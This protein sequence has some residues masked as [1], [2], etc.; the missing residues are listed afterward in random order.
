VSGVIQ[1]ET[2]IWLGLTIGLVFIIIIVAIAL[3]NSDFKPK[4]SLIIVSIL[5][6][7]IV[8]GVL[9]WMSTLEK[10]RSGVS[11]MKEALE[12]AKSWW[13]NESG[14][15]LEIAQGRGRSI[16]DPE[17]GE[18][19]FGFLLA[20]MTS[21]NPGAYIVILVGGKPRD[22]VDWFDDPPPILIKNPLAYKEKEMKY[23]RWM[24]QDM[25]MR[26]RQP[27]GSIPIHFE[28]TTPRRQEPQDFE[29]GG[30]EKK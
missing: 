7:I 5:A 21:T 10:K 30:E 13:Y 14:E 12:Y 1:R 19:T 29:K 16:A 23:K 27:S 25:E 6:V 8:G 22:I 24:A 11:E 2:K 15:E 26:R 4:P 17:T 28:P 20:R 18:K 9:I 3:W